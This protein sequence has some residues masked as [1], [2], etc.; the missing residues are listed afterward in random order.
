MKKIFNIN[1]RLNLSLFIGN[2]VL[3]LV[4]SSFIYEK[5]NYKEL[6]NVYIDGIVSGLF[7][8]LGYILF[9][10]YVFIKR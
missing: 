5:Y 3:I 7:Y 2:I 8:T 1:K 6:I 9:L 4:L 10:F